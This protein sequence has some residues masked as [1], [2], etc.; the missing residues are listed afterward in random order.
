MP[1]ANRYVLPGSVCH[2]T[3]R[4]HDRKFLFRFKAHRQ[5]YRQRLREV[6]D[7]SGVS[8][9][10]WCLT[11]NHVHLLVSAEE[12]AAI[13][14]FMQRLQGEFAKWY[15]VR[16]RRSG[17]FWNGRYHC[18]MVENGEHLWRCM[19]YIDLNMVRAGAVVHPREW[20][21]CGYDEL[22]GERRKFLVL[23]REKLL[24]LT[25]TPSATELARNHQAMIAEAL[26]AHRL[27]REAQWTDSIAVGS[28]EFVNGVADAN[29]WRARLEIRP[30]EGDSWLVRETEEPYGLLP[31]GA[32]A[33]QG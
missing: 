23:D 30:G 9:L 32:E 25:G 10:S 18:T 7:G 19:R 20:R 17:A 12:P 28:R 16:R 33:E 29:E 2:L 5:E 14:G 24:E 6:L 13:A 3:H 1:V 11:S 22:A 21:W 27:G 4:C 31:A 8:L 26:E 15:N